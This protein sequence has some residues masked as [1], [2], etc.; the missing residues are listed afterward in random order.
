MNFL[1]IINYNA[2]LARF[3]GTK[4]LNIG[5]SSTSDVIYSVLYNDFYVCI[6]LWLDFGGRI[7]ENYVHGLKAALKRRFK[8]NICLPFT[9]EKECYINIQFHV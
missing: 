5:I 8:R 1:Y 9:L 2:S 4:Y 6:W 3:S 7:Y